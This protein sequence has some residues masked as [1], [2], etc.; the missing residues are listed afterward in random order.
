[1]HSQL[2]HSTFPMLRCIDR[3]GPSSSKRQASGSLS[4][5]FFFWFFATGLNIA[6]HDL[7][8]TLPY[9]TLPCPLPL[10]SL[11]GPVRLPS[12]A[13]HLPRCGHRFSGFM[14]WPPIIVQLRKHRKHNRKHTRFVGLFWLHLHTTTTVGMYVCNRT[15]SNYCIENIN[16]HN[17]G[18]EQGGEELHCGPTGPNRR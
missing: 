6:L 3:W 4:V 12:I 7:C 15:V 18:G 5:F 1:V 2:S 8:L 11:P 9:H 10:C 17:H 14:Q 13:F 16:H